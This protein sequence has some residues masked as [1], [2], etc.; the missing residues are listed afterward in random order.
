MG[1]AVS[2]RVVVVGGG[3][4]GVTA[5]LWCADAGARVTLLE[6]RPRLGG[7][8]WSFQRHGIW[9]DNGQHVFLRCCTAYR[10][11]LARLGTEDLTILQERLDIPVL[12]RGLSPAHLRRSRLPAPLHLLP[13]LAR[14][15]P[16]GLADRARAAAAA[17]ALARLD[18]EDPAL[19]AQSFGS[20]LDRHRQSPAAVDR[21]WDLIA[22]PALNLPAREA[23]L[24]L[25]AKVFRTGLL[26]EAD[27]G[28]IGWSLVPLGQLH[29]D[30]AW[31]ALAEAG[32]EVRL[33]ARASAV[34]LGPA[35]SGL[36]VV[37]DGYRLPAGAVISAVPHDA[38]ARLLPPEAAGNRP[39]GELGTSPIVDVHVVYD[40]RVTELPMAAAL[41]S[42]VQWVFDRT[43]SS[44]L[45]AGQYLAVSVSGA[46]RQL[47]RSPEELIREATMALAELF[48]KAAGA[49]VHD[50]FVTK[51]PAATFRQAPGT[52]ALRPGPRAGVAGLYLAG[53]WTDT[54]WP[55]T[56]EGA[57]R[58]G[59]AAA[60][61]AMARL[62]GAGTATSGTAPGAEVSPPNAAERRS[63]VPTVRTSNL[64]PLTSEV[65][66]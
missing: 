3:L 66:S 52:R 54:G 12:R 48:P 59:Q 24:G 11:L 42:A 46:A 31:R 18:P 19:D 45:E 26:D 44:G 40:R 28:D 50:A 14:Y 4:A 39:L 30:A 22:L 6:S 61:C 21:L 55:A 49:R 23:S 38:A 51:E 8:T 56:M 32:V 1:S 34:D 9:A 7:A 47:G 16:L 62:S 53:A 37:C 36:E 29:G 41:G 2:D 10:G 63:T 27:A 60:A 20:F 58:S 13:A 35:G 33:R 64:V 57:V 17:R 65:T 43:A 25:A 15:R 5:A